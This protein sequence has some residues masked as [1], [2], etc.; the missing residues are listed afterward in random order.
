[1]NKVFQILIRYTVQQTMVFGLVVAL[2]F[3]FMAY[4]DGSTYIEETKRIQAEIQTK[5][6]RKMDTDATL[7]EEARMKEAVGLLSMQYQEI[8]RRLPTNLTSIELNR[9]IDAFA[10]NSSVS[11][12]SRRPLSLVNKE[13]VD[14]VPVEVTL[15]G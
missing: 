5:E 6:A 7:K 1:M 8:S 4:D 2:I 14:E 10:R 9:N 15:E 3:Y 13:I 11:I 12:K